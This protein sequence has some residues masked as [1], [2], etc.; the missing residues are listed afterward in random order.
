MMQ[1]WKDKEDTGRNGV[2]YFIAVVWW[3]AVSTAT[4]VSIGQRILEALK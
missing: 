1:E 4:I 2:M 3:L